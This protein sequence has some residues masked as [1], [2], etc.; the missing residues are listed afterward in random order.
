MCLFASMDKAPPETLDIKNIKVNSFSGK[1]ILFSS[2]KII[3]NV[4][5]NLCHGQQQNGKCLQILKSANYLQRTKILLQVSA[6]VS[7]VQ[8]IL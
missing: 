3:Q 6:Y 1:S 7:C 5:D 4:I 2:V 8:R